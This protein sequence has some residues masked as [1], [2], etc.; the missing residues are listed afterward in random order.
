M[1]SKDKKYDNNHHYSNPMNLW[2]IIQVIIHKVFIEKIV[3]LRNSQKIERYLEIGPG[4]V[5][6]K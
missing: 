5:R 6:I 3:K 1:R 2:S 4:D